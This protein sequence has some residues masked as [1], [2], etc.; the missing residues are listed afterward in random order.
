MKMK[1]WPGAAAGAAEPRVLEL[2][3]DRVGLH[4]LEG[5]LQRRVAAVALVA[6]ERAQPG[7]LGVLQQHPGLELVRHPASP[8]RSRCSRPFSASTSAPE[9]S[10]PIAVAASAASSRPK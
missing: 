4:L 6:L 2:L 10:C 7:V 1:A 9:A 3:E 5:L 8:A